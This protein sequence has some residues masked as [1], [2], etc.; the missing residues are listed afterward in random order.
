MSFKGMD[1]DALRGFAGRLDAT[2]TQLQHVHGSLG[3]RLHQVAWHGAVADRFTG[4]WFGAYRSQVSGACQQLHDL[5]AALRAE[6]SA[7]DG[8]SGGALGAAGSFTTLPF[9]DRGF[10]IPPGFRPVIPQGSHHVPAGLLP[11]LALGLVPW[12]QRGSRG[13]GPLVGT[14]TRPTMEQRLTTLA[15]GGSLSKDAAWQASRTA[16]ASAR[17]ETTVAGIPMQ[18]TATATATAEAHANARASVSLKGADISATAGASV[19]ATA[20][21]VGSVGSR[22]LGVS[23]GAGVTAQAS[24]DAHASAHVDGHG[25]TVKA[26]AEVGA[27]VSAD[28]HVTAH[29]GGVDTTLGAHAY[30]GVQAHA[31]GE[32]VVTAHDVKAHVSVGASL[33]IGAGVDVTVEVHPDQVWSTLTGRHDTPGLAQHFTPVGH[34]W[35]QHAV[36][37][38]S[39][40]A[41]AHFSLPRSLAR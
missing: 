21:V 2:A 9:G 14:I 6:A 40:Q 10:A 1:P 38:V 28:A 20:A 34:Q 39:H 31:Q 8:A 35:V 26:G 7:Q 37:T 29:T 22:N 33:G 25:A 24:A 4:D 23:G 30:A 5:A 41:D 13:I 27:S 36:S 15:R 18:G 32:A 17:G 19:I 11:G 3:G 16:T 12:I